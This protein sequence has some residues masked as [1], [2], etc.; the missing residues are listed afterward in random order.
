MDKLAIAGAGNF[1]IGEYYYSTVSPR[2]IFQEWLVLE[3]QF[4]L[5]EADAETITCASAHDA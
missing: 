3:P 5:R 2:I 4:I 1:R